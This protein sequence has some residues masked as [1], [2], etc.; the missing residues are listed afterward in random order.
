MLYWVFLGKRLLIGQTL[1]PMAL[2]GCRVLRANGV[3][4][5]DIPHTLALIVTFSVSFTQPLSPIAHLL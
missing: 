1:L 2:V 3:A 4:I 5:F